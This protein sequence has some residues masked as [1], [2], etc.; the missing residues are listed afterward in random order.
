MD[1]S[2]ALSQPLLG[3]GRETSLSGMPG[4]LGFPGKRKKLSIL[5]AAENREA[6]EDPGING[7]SPRSAVGSQ[8]S[9]ALKGQIMLLCWELKCDMCSSMPMHGL[10]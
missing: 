3:N 7:V 2:Q 8:V 5:P 1:G 9:K 10:G 6:L 4:S